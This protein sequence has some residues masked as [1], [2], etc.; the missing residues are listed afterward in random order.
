[1]PTQP[2]PDLTV[3]LQHKHER[4]GK[5]ESKGRKPNEEKKEKRT[6]EET[7]KSVEREEGEIMETRPDK[8]GEGEQIARKASAKRGENEK[9]GIASD[10][11]WNRGEPTRGTR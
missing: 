7:E 5:G 8:G 4:S 3:K 2:E 11:I 10:G 6:E 9:R 1:V